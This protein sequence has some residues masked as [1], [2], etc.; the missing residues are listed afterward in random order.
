[1]QKPNRTKSQDTENTIAGRLS[2]AFGSLIVSV[3]VCLF[4][5][6]LFNTKYALIS[7]SVIPLHYF[8]WFIVS[9]SSFGFISPKAIPNILGWLLEL[10]FGASRAP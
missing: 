7:G 3:P 5:W 4:L 2:A 1:M 8:I 9:L 10:A 6:F